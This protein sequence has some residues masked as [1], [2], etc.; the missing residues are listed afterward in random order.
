GRVYA[1]SLPPI[2][3]RLIL[4]T[5]R[6]Q[7]HHRRLSA[8]ISELLRPESQNGCTGCEFCAPR[9]QGPECPPFSGEEIPLG[10]SP[11][12]VP[13]CFEE[14]DAGARISSRVALRDL[15]LCR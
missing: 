3:H 7:R 4:T 6:L 9:H 11:P 12:R 15:N 5:F 2:L 8:A 13:Q 14:V 1:D 10:L